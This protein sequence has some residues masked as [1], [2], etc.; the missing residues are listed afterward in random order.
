VR[1]ADDRY[2][3]QW[4]ALPTDLCLTVK[5]RVLSREPSFIICG[6]QGCV[7][8][9]MLAHPRRACLV[10]ISR[11]SVLAMGAAALRVMRSS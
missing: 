5:V 6:R 1:R 9:I 2:G 10:P 3:G 8:M 4:D 7:N 11:F